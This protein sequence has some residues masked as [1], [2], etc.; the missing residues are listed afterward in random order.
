MRSGPR[1]RHGPC[2][3]R[4]S[5]DSLFRTGRAYARRPWSVRPF[6]HPRQP[7]ETAADA[8]HHDRT[9]QGPGDA[10]DHATRKVELFDPHQPG[11]LPG[12]L[13][14]LDD[15]DPPNHRSGVSHNAPSR[16][17]PLG[18]HHGVTKAKL[19]DAGEGLE[20][21]ADTDAVRRVRS[22]VS[23]EHPCR[24]RGQSV[25]ASHTTCGQHR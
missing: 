11:T 12:Q 8:P 13:L 15:A 3:V 24:L 20:L 16:W 17:L 21:A 19:S 9:R 10:S 2:L 7:P 6:E 18:D 4:F 5:G 22:D 14:H 1:E 23:T 25:T